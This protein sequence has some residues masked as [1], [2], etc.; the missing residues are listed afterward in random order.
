MTLVATYGRMTDELLRIPLSHQGEEVGEL[1]LA[2]RSPGESFTAADRRL[3]ADVERQAGAIIHMVVLTKNLQ[4]SQERLVTA[5]EEERRRLRRDLHDGLGPVL[6]S[7]MLTI[8]A[9]RTLMRSDPARAETL[10]LDLKKQTQQALSDIRRLVYELRPPALDLGLASALLDLVT[11]YSQSQI[12]I[13]LEVQEPLPALTAAVDVAL[14]RITQEA[15]ANVVRHSQAQHCQVRIVWQDNL[16][17]T[18]SD[19]G[20]GLPE[21]YRA[22][23]GLN[24]MR[25]RATELGGRCTIET[26]PSGG[27]CIHVRLP[28]LKEQD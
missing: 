18:I 28:I 4:H 17:L 5:R 19:D 13:T 21:P 15:L 2:P 6:G 22:G 8:D 10:L 12:E 1:Q 9:V 27:V 7:H 14:Y 23:V 25:E 3:L 16:Y 20:R 24:S 26:Q 11:Q